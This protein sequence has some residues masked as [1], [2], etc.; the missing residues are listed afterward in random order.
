MSLE[1]RGVVALW[2]GE[3]MWLRRHV[4][5][6]RQAAWVFGDLAGSVFDLPAHLATA[7][8]YTAQA[9]RFVTEK[10]LFASEQLRR[11]HWILPAVGITCTS[12]FVVAKS[13]P[14]GTYRA[15]RN[16]AVTAV[17][18]T[19]FLLPREIVDAVDAELPFGTSDTHGVDENAK[20]LGAK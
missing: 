5:V 14:W 10:T 7:R 11:S 1:D 6:V 2:E 15:F 17:L 3:W 8:V 9:D 20:N 12:L 18:L 16:G 19:C 13:A 4:S